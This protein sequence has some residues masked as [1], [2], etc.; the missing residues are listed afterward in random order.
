[1]TGCH[2]GVWL[3]KNMHVATPNKM[4]ILEK[5]MSNIFFFFRNLGILFYLDTLCEW[6]IIS[7]QKSSDIKPW[8]WDGFLWN[9]HHLIVE[10][11]FLD[12]AQKYGGPQGPW[13]TAWL[14]APWCSMMFHPQKMGLLLPGQSL[15][16]NIESMNI[17]IVQYIFWSQKT[18]EQRF[19]LSFPH[20]FSKK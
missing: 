6:Y 13:Y 7:H 20:Q 3:V 2:W 18:P 10:V 4:Q 17:N 16:L 14:V 15:S 12:F 8:N 19:D 9:N 11:R 5:N 1:M